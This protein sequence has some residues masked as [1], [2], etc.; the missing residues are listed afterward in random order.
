MGKDSNWL[1][2]DSSN[3]MVTQGCGCCAEFKSMKNATL[4]DLT[5]LALNLKEQSNRVIAE[6][7][8]RAVLLKKSI[9]PAKPK[10][11]V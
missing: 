8:T 4:Q 1:Y 3:D 10:G 9:D 11:P 2:L 5:T 6:L 7:N